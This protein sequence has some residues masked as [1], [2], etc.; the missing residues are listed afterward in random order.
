MYKPANVV[1]LIN[2]SEEVA[3]MFLVQTIVFQLKQNSTYPTY[4]LFHLIIYFMY[5][6]YSMTPSVDFTLKVHYTFKQLHI[7]DFSVVCLLY[8]LYCQEQ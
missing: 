8:H 1:F 7:V 5:S 4:I 3:F 6:V 2:V